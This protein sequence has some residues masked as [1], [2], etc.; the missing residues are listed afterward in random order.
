MTGLAPA[1]E[2]RGGTLEG[3]GPNMC[4]CGTTSGFCKHFGG[5]TERADMF[6][7]SVTVI[8][9]EAGEAAEV[10][11]GLSTPVGLTSEVLRSGACH[12]TVGFYLCGLRSTLVSSCAQ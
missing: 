2:M 6:Q 12:N 10:P 7:Y 8:P 9:Q 5:G 3:P 4:R 11:S 1:S